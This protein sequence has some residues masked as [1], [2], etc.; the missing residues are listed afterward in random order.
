[1][2]PY[3]QLLWLAGGAGVLRWREGSFVPVDAGGAGAR[4]LVLIPEAFSR[5]Y[6]AALRRAAWHQEPREHRQRRGSRERWHT[7]GARVDGQQA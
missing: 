4:E 6:G 3:A 7:K 1:M 5:V 2:S